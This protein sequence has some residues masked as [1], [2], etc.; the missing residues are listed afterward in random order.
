MPLSLFTFPIRLGILTLLSEPRRPSKKA[1]PEPLMRIL[2]CPACRSLEAR[3]SHRHGLERLL[4][5]LGIFPYRCEDC[6]TRFL[7]LKGGRP[8]SASAARDRIS[9]VA[10]INAKRSLAS[11]L[12]PDDG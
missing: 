11:G 4:S 9:D 5:L 3:R 12:A 1:S 10:P 2:C 8:P 6:L 7:A